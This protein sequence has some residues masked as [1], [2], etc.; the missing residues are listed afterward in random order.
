MDDID[1][2]LRAGNDN[3]RGAYLAPFY[4]QAKDIAWGYV[5]Q[6]TAKIPG[7]SI[8]ES[9][10]RVDFPNGARY[11]LYGADNYDRLRGLYFDHVT[12]DE[13][14]D[15]D[16]RAWPEVIRPALSDRKGTATFIG[17][18]KGR[19]A[20][21]DVHEYSQTDRNWFSAVLRASE[22]GLIDAEELEDARQS[23]TPEQFEQEYECSFDAA[24]VGAFYSGEMAALN[25]SGRIRELEISPD[26]PVQTFW[27]LGM[28]DS[29]AIWCVQN[30]PGE[31]RV[32]DYI[33]DSGKA[34]SHYAMELNARG[35]RGTAWLPH[36]AKAR[37]LGTGRTREETLRELGFSVRVVPQHR[38][39]DG[40]NAARLMLNRC[41]FDRDRTANG[42]EALVNYRAEYDEK[43]KV[44]K[45]NPLH[46]W[47]S[48]GADA[49]RT[50]AMS[51]QAM[52]AEPD[53]VRR[54]SDY[55]G[56]DDDDEADSWKT[57]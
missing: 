41:Y 20:F 50:F 17:T 38:V 44:F 49:F 28:R 33:E 29:M 34:L 14:G 10:L 2:A 13:Y 18:P 8:N 37:E 54:R 6:Y 22:T 7:V 19:N 12:L 11:R 47:A 21:Y 57:V 3:W 24:I 31:P 9:E 55:G 26:I 36:D 16:P 45:A 39:M 43:N 48:H 56:W 46:N 32:V 42:R 27:D 25:K 30:V 15:M 5:K 51:W 53:P 35:Y 40:I 52:K 23:M 4:T 1:L